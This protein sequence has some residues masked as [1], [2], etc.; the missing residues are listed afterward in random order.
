M[1]AN[2]L[3]QVA[4]REHVH[5]EHCPDLHELYGN[6]VSSHCIRLHQEMKYAEKDRDEDG[7]PCI[8]KIDT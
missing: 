8:G 2:F 3:E 7:C 6:N 1:Q 4:G 5:I